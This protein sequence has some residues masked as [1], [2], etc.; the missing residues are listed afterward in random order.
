[1]VI[2]QVRDVDAQ[3]VQRFRDLW[4]RLDATGPTLQD[5]DA[6][7]RLPSPASDVL[8][9]AL[10]PDPADR[11]QTAAEFADVLASHVGGGKAEAARVMQTLFG[12]ELR[13][14]AA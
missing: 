7:R 1:M 5:Y 4:R 13:K 10:A 12:D 2:S 11:F 6:I 14:E 3:F 9:R 8:G